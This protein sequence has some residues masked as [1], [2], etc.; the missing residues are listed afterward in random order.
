V[1]ETWIKV[2]KHAKGFEGRSSVKTWLYRVAINR[3][4]DLAA[5]K[6]ARPAPSAIVQTLEAANAA[7]ESTG[8][9]DDLAGLHRAMAKLAEP[10]RLILLLCYHRGLTLAQAAEVLNIPLG[11]LKSRLHAA[12]NELRATLSKEERS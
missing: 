4:R 7:G 10:A 12:L 5:S 1:Q 3:A 2:I 8:D 11:T 9:P 6:M